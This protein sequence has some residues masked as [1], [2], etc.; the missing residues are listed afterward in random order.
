M[1]KNN[2]FLL[3]F[4]TIL[5]YFILTILYHNGYSWIIPESGP[6]GFYDLRVVLESTDC[7]NKG[8]DPYI[9]TNKDCPHLYNYPFVWIWLTNVF[10]LTIQNVYL[11]GFGMIFSFVLSISFLFRKI[12]L[13]NL[14]LLVITLIS[15][16][17]LL[18][19]DRAN[20]DIII[21]ILLLIASYYL[22]S[23]NITHTKVHFSYLLILIATML[24]IYPVFILGL[25]L[26]DRIDIKHKYIV[27]VYSTITLSLYTFLNLKEILV[28]LGNTPH[29]S[30]LAFGKNVLIQEFLSPSKLVYFSFLPFI[31]MM[32]IVFYKRVF[33]KQLVTRLQLDTSN[34]G[35]LFFGGVLLFTGTY[36]FGNNWD[37]R[38]VFAIFFLPYLFSDHIKNND[39]NKFKNIFIVLLVI[40]LFTSFIHRSGYFFNSYKSW[41]IGRNLLMG[42]KYLIVTF[43]T[44]FGFYIIFYYIM[45]QIDILKFTYKKGD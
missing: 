28:L 25:I 5:I 36:F 4:L 14:I 15:P 42:L 20:I 32:L 13:S 35:K 18:L 19:L 10:K 23:G 30:E 37:Y 1:I 16:P 45:Q 44:A 41:F 39:L 21:F 40:V 33:F 7:Y 43:F 29:P 24:K 31:V 3:F 38:L 22:R 11:I 17:I 12:T 26:I 34:E 9:T 2:S 6:P 8:Y 27:V